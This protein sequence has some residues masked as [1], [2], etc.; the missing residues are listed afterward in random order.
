LR[1]VQDLLP[2]GARVCVLLDQFEEFFNL[3]Q[4][5]RERFTKE[6]ADCLLSEPPVGH[7]L[8]SIQSARVGYLST[9]APEISQ[10]LAN[11]LVLPPLTPNQAREAILGPA[12]MAGMKVEDALVDA[13]LRDLGGD[14]ID[15][16]EIQL[17]CHTLALEACRGDRSLTLDAY[18]KSGRAETILR[19]HLSLVLRRN[20]PAEDQETAWQALAAVDAHP[21]GTARDEVVA[22]LKSREIGQEKALRMLEILELNRLVRIR[23]GVYRLTSASLREPVRKW[24]EQRTA[25]EQA[26]IEARR[27]LERVRDSALRGL[28]GGGVAFSLAF[29][30]TYWFQV[31][32]NEM[33]F[34]PILAMLDAL[35][36][37]AAGV[38]F[39][40][41]LDIVRASFHWR[42]R[43]TQVL[44][45]GIGGA[46][47]FALAFLFLKLPNAT[48]L[49]YS[50][51]L[52]AAA[53]GGLWGLVVGAAIAAISL[54][55]RPLWQ[56]VPLFTVLSTAALLL[57]ESFG[58]VYQRPHQR[59]NMLLLQVTIAL[60]GALM[61]LILTWAALLGR[62]REAAAAETAPREEK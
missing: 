21:G 39:I 43:L 62:R 8:I 56:T 42:R 28:F 18:E 54:T 5:E 58:G 7:W 40:F 24:K 14:A 50:E 27:Q 61:F 6:L 46:V 35:A 9:L 30:I 60:A 25:R 10:P 32:V 16:S 11:T 34:I 55:R 52:L 19:D 3:P 15:P 22:E 36:G 48:F 1:E 33:S 38:A 13:L 41:L 20:L 2:E 4:A 26:Q 51:L 17:I 45:G 29:I 57:G 53:Q 49:D 47:I 37:G 23:E 59:P 12:D 44:L 31:R